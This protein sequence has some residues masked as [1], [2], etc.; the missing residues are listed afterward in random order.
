MMHCIFRPPYTAA[1]RHRSAGVFPLDSVSF[2]TAHNPPFILASS[3]PV[4]TQSPWLRFPSNATTS[5]AIATARRRATSLCFLSFAKLSFS[6]PRYLFL[7]TAN[8]CPASHLVN[9]SAT[10][11]PRPTRFD[12]FIRS[13]LRYNFDD[14]FEISVSARLGNIYVESRLSAWPWKRANNGLGENL[15]EPST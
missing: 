8:F 4:L 12:R 15:G 1:A 11:T 6:L 13:S 2:S 14:V 7:G 9:V 3:L 5:F 10:R